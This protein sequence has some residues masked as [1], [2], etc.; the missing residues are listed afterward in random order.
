MPKTAFQEKKTDGL[1]TSREGAI[2]NNVLTRENLEAIKQQG[3][4]VTGEATVSPG[5][6]A[7]GKRAST[8]AAGDD[9]GPSSSLKRK[10]LPYSPTTAEGLSLFTQCKNKECF[11]TI[12]SLT[13]QTV[14]SIYQKLTWIGDLSVTH[15]IGVDMR[16]VLP[17]DIFVVS[18]GCSTSPAIFFSLTQLSPHS[19]NTFQYQRT[20]YDAIKTFCV[21]PFEQLAQQSD[22]SG[23][24]APFDAGCV[25]IA[26]CEVRAS[27]RRVFPLNKNAALNEKSSEGVSSGRTAGGT[28]VPDPLDSFFSVLNARF[29][30]GFCQTLDNNN[31]IYLVPKFSQSGSV[32]PNIVSPMRQDASALA[33]PAGESADTIAALPAEQPS[34]TSATFTSSAED[35]I[36]KIVNQCENASS[37]PERG[38][39]DAFI[40][41]L[42]RNLDGPTLCTSPSVGELEAQGAV[43]SSPPSRESRIP[44]APSLEEWAKENPGRVAHA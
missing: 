44:A 6:K 12:T 15:I 1:G 31:Q 36:W 7:L 29:R 27:S 22:G 41:M 40:V 25:M 13:P 21:P 38:T 3:S 14:C 8:A 43:L 20:V 23:L 2:A 5:G 28:D 10:R 32:A 37:F 18:L 16:C 19:N 42:L 35:S 9:G 11:R 24:Q 17:K 26:R 34:T 33:S 39:E 4:A 30:V